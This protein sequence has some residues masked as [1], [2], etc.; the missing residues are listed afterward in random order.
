[1]NNIIDDVA[2]GKVTISVRPEEF[3]VG[4]GGLDVIVKT[5]TFLGKY[6]TY[7]VEFIL[8]NASS[9]S[10]DNLLEFSQDIGQVERIYN[11]GEKITLKPSS[12]KMN[13]FTADG[14]QSIIKGVKQYG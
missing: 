7:E 5:R 10:E 12:K 13:I 1:M 3:V 6:V 8:D 9:A 4:I 2:E 11:N 14:T